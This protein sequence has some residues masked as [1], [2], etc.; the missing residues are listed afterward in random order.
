MKIKYP[1][2]SLKTR[3]KFRPICSSAMFI[4]LY[5]I[6]VAEFDFGEPVCLATLQTVLYFIQ[7][8]CLA[9]QN[10]LAFP[11]KIFVSKNYPKIPVVWDRFQYGNEDDYSAFYNF[12]TTEH[13][14]TTRFDSNQSSVYWWNGRKIAQADPMYYDSLLY[15]ELFYDVIFDCLKYSDWDLLKILDSQEAW[16]KATYF[17]EKNNVDCQSIHINWYDEEDICNFLF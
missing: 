14:T 8:N 2:E 9:C 4:A 15:H 6:Y 17:K 16:E 1:K 12:I 3:L 7:A 11:D 10:R 5:V 13:T